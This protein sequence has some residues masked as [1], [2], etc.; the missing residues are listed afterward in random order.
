MKKKIIGV[1][2]SLCVA[3]CI[4]PTEPVKAETC[5][6]LA[7]Q[8]GLLN[9]EP[10]SQMAVA[11]AYFDYQE[12]FKVPV[13]YEETPSLVAP[14]TPGKL[15]LAD[16]QGGLT[17]INS[18]RVI[19]NLN[20]VTLNEELSR[21]AQLGS[22]RFAFD[23]KIPADLTSDYFREA[24]YTWLTWGG[25]IFGGTADASDRP[26]AQSVSGHFYNLDE[27]RPSANMQVLKPGL[28]SV[29]FGRTNYVESHGSLVSA[30]AVDCG[31]KSRSET[32]DWD[33]VAWPSAGYFPSEWLNNGLYS[34]S[35]FVN[36]LKYDVLDEGLKVE[37]TTPWNKTYTV[38]T[39]EK[40]I[41]NAFPGSYDGASIKL[42]AGN[43]AYF[44]FQYHD[45]TSVDMWSGDWLTESYIGQ[46][47]TYHFRWTGL[48][49]LETG[50]PATIEYDTYAFEAEQFRGMDFPE[51]EPE[52]TP[53]PDEPNG[54]ENLAVEGE[55]ILEDGQWKY[56]QNGVQNME[57][58]GYVA[59]DGNYFLV[60]NGT[61]AT[62][63]SGLAVDPDH[64]DTWYYLANGMVQTQYTGLTS[65]DGA[66]FYVNKGRLDTKKTGYV[67][68][69]GGLF[70]VGLGRIMTEVNGL[71]QDT[72]TKAWYYLAG[73]QV[74]KQ[75]SGLCQ[76][77]GAWFYVINGKLAS[78]YSGKVTYNGS[79]FEVV[80][81]MLKS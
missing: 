68:Y 1:L 73:G 28:N 3:L 80:N 29:G 59:F 16:Q 11:K 55:L 56:Y 25:S 8:S 20:K 46:P 48:K 31:Y 57:K 76:Y 7:T 50:A 51:E 22:M 35:M 49:D 17:A 32:S 12:A 71:A 67:Q 39:T 53:E 78:N 62:Q 6:H 41:G 24:H 66:W 38:D 52:P 63:I 69:D 26:T 45:M 10:A 33:F 70:Y 23:G 9:Q 60:A 21:K 30:M 4:V 37:I 36:N 44:A 58:Y 27:K 14:Y 15:S 5:K 72:K 43:N 65:Y 79:L 34:T 40:P 77:D 13:A 19:A 42:S 61:V 18:L 47:G 75:Y 81:G 54:L 64:P 2:L 74:Q